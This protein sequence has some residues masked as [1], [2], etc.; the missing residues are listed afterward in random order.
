MGFKEIMKKTSLF[1]FSVAI[2]ICTI[3]SPLT[4]YAY[5][6]ERSYVNEA[7]NWEVKDADGPT[8]T[9]SM[10]MMMQPEY[11]ASSGFRAC[12][13]FWC[14]DGIFN[15]KNGFQDTS[16]QM[17]FYFRAENAN[18][19]DIFHD[20]QIW[21]WSFNIEPGTYLFC[22]PEGLN[23]ITVLTKTLGSPFYNDGYTE[24]ETTVVKDGDHIRLYCMFGDWEWRSQDDQL[25]SLQAYAEM[26]EEKLNY[27]VSKDNASKTKTTISVSNKN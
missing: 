9:V 8:V 22:E 18:V 11:A 1:L 12:Y 10:Y 17:E 3:V 15:Y 4:T 26:R 13:G 5:D 7:G 16:A 21:Y 27:G 23:N 20:Y 24:P 6:E 14:E 25:Y 19:V 2:C